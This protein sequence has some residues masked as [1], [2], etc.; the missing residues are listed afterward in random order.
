[1]GLTDTEVRKAKAAEKAYR[2][3]DSHSL[4]LWVT[5]SGGKLWRWAYN[6]DGKEKL[7][8]LGK[9]PAVTLALA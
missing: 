5:P 4:Y 8:A 9:Y 6:F 7:M 3:S 2:V 1:M